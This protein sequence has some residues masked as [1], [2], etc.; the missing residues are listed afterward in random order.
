MASRT[1]Q[2]TAPAEDVEGIVCFDEASKQEGNQLA[3][4]DRVWKDAIAAK[5]QLKRANGS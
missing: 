5:R 1:S 4:K 3:D 2:S